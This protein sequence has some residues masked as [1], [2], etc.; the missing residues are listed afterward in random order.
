MPYNGAV[1]GG[2]LQWLEEELAGAEQQG[3]RV[4]ILSHVG[5]APRSQNES[6][7]IWNYE[8][9]LSVCH[10]SPSL[11]LVL[12]GHAHRGGYVEDEHGVH[13]VTVQSPLECEET[14][15]AF[16][17]A[18]VYSDRI[19]LEGEGRVPTRVLPLR[20]IKL[21]A[22]TKGPDTEGESERGLE[23]LTLSDSDKLNRP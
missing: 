21:P 2:Q 5:L 13:H 20:S 4:V 3:E 12:A 19:E 8:K 1:G 18:H 22:V 9:V 7:L 23:K 14:E 11:C 17:T 15:T 6:C 10:A 16:A